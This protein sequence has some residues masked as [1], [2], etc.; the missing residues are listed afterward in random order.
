VWRV[1][2]APIARCAGQRA[3]GAVV[4]RC[5]P[6]RMVGRQ[7]AR[8]QV[9]RHGRGHRRR[10]GGVFG[11]IVANGGVRSPCEEEKTAEDH[12]RRHRLWRLRSMPD[13]GH[14]PSAPEQRARRMGRWRKGVAS[15]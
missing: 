8:G 9:R 6:C 14:Q 13:A 15:R 12:L 5:G 7:P 10:E 1:S 3:A 2:S 11:R 4:R